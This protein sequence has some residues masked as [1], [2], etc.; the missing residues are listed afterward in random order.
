MEQTA[1]Q[2]IV[3]RA[4]IVTIPKRVPPALQPRS[5]Y[6]QSPHFVTADSPP[7]P[8]PSPRP[9][10]RHEKSASPMYPPFQPSNREAEKST[11]HE[12]T[13]HQELSQNFD[14]IRLSNP[15]PKPPSHSKTSAFDSNS[16]SGSDYSPSR[17]TPAGTPGLGAETDDTVHTPITME[18]QEATP[19]KA[20]AEQPSDSKSTKMEREASQASEKDDAFHSMPS[21]PVEG[22]NK[23]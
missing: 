8:I 11:I 5:P 9:E 17:S 7:P 18:D 12:S 20:G 19:T 10:D 2:P 1:P 15:S 16:V 22:G 23:V 21:T 13:S 14:S 4:R 6:R 3:S